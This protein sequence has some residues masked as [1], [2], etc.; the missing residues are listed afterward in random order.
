MAAPGMQELH[1]KAQPLA[2][3][4]GQLCQV[5][6]VNVNATSTAAMNL[7]LT[8][9]AACYVPLFIRVPVNLA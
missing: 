1:D 6:Q 8:T 7:S 9:A 4:E 2:L 5:F 3:S